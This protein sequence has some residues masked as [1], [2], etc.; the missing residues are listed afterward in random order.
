MSFSGIIAIYVT[1][2][3]EG[4]YLASFGRYRNYIVIWF[5]AYV[6]GLFACSYLVLCNLG[7][8]NIADWDEARHG[9]NAYEMVES[10][11]YIVNT[12]SHEYDYWNLKPPL[13]Y[14][15]IAASYQLFGFSPFALRLYSALSFILLAVIC[16]VFL[17]RKYSLRA[18]AILVWI[19]AGCKSFVLAQHLFR[20]G[21][22]DALF[23]LFHTVG[24]IA[25]MCMERNQKWLCV[26]TLCVSLAFLTKSW[27]AATLF[28]IIAVVL[29]VSGKWKKLTKQ[30]W[31]G[32]TICLIGP[33]I[34]W[35]MARTM[36][37]GTKFFEEMVSYDLLSRSSTVF[38]SQVY[39]PLFYVEQLLASPDIVV[40]LLIS[41]VGII[42]V[43]IKKKMAPWRNY[44]VLCLV[45][46]IL[47]PL[48]LF[49]IVRT[50]L[51]WYVYSAYPVIC[52]SAA[53]CIESF[54]HYVQQQHGGGSPQ[55]RWSY[56][57]AYCAYRPFSPTRNSL[58]K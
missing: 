27:H 26:S 21:D 22:A 15:L 58:T 18:G 1:E 49:S 57:A 52:L 17:I 37:D 9:V 12:Y 16:S 41:I 55:L 10:G 47:V 54:M 36:A 2:R 56:L 39:G 30:T 19:L 45:V 34:I 35:M 23:V 46:G 43:T 4:L 5:L 53:I 13:S 3:R 51:Y 8:G 42:A 50:K 33:V 28:V 44:T 20:S 29:F 7:G 32:A 6:A 31:I 40:L 25:L 14:W 48:V 11:N 24:I 38:N